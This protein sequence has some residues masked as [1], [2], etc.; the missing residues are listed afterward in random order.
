VS[1]ARRRVASS[2]LLIHRRRA[3]RCTSVRR[4]TLFDSVWLGRRLATKRRKT[5]ELCLS[6]PWQ[7]ARLL[8]KRLNGGREER[9][10]PRSRRSRLVLMLPPL[11]KSTRPSRAVI[12]QFEPA[13]HQ[14]PAPSSC[15]SLLPRPQRARLLR[16]AEGRGQ[17]KQMADARREPR[18]SELRMIIKHV[19]LAQ[20]LAAGQR[21]R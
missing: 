16:S 3:M 13:R 18:R 1:V 20:Q 14:P 21:G 5:E 9:A 10:V 11:R 6:L 19:A 12:H 8:A 4:S 15:T 7:L 17:P 2:I